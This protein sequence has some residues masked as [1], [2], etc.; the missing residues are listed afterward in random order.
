MLRALNQGG[1]VRLYPFQILTWNVLGQAAA[2][3]L[4]GLRLEPVVKVDRFWFS[5]A[6]A[7][8]LDTRV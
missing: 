1:D 6:A 5:W 7:F 8:R 3:A 2:G 4:T